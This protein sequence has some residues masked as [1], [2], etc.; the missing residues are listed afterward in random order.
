MDYYMFTIFFDTFSSRETE[1]VTPGYCYRF[2]SRRFQ[3]VIICF[4]C[5]RKIRLDVRF[6]KLS[7]LHSLK[8]YHN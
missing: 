2:S 8:T 7:L 5:S 3:C 6:V 4:C 1:I